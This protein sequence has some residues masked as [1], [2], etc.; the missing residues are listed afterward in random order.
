MMKSEIQH[1]LMTSKNVI[2]LRNEYL[3]DSLKK[4]DLSRSGKWF[5]GRILTM[6]SNTSLNA[7]Q[8]K[9]FKV[10]HLN[11]PGVGMYVSLWHS[12][13]RFWNGLAGS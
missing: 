6:G 5:F 12:I 7:T 2:P 8:F 9:N 13:R 4:R 10:I 11:H 3:T 1:L